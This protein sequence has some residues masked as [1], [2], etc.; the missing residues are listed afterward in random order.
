MSDDAQKTPGQ[1]GY[2][3]F[4]RVH[5]AGREFPSPAWANVPELVR[6]AWEAAMKAAPSVDDGSAATIADL[7]VK[8]S[9]ANANI[10]ALTQQVQKVTAE[11]KAAND[12]ADAA[13]KALA[14]QQTQSPPA[15]Q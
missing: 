15:T 2:E 1:V 14:D 8:L 10:T 11:A 9:A 3:E 6:N 5:D 7:T 13:E 12:R 4:R